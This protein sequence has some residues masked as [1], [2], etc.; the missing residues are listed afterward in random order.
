MPQLDMPTWQVSATLNRTS[1]SHGQVMCNFFK[2]SNIMTINYDHQLQKAGSRQRP[3]HSAAVSS[4]RQCTA[5]CAA[6]ENDDHSYL[7]K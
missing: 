4:L 2:R 3:M 5:P 1:L 6:A 7:N